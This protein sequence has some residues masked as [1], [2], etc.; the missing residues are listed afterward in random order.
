MQAFALQASPERIT[1]G[2]AMK[3]WE[4]SRRQ[5]RRSWPVL[6]ACGLICVLG[7]AGAGFSPLASAASATVQTLHSFT[8]DGEFP[9]GSLVQA[10]DG[11]FYGTTYGGGA[12]GNGTVFR[13]TPAGALTTVFSFDGAQGRG[14]ISGLSVGSDG[15]L[16]GTT[17]S[18]G[19]ND[20]GTVFRITVSGALTT[21]FH[22]DNTNGAFPRAA[23]LLASDGKIFGAVGQGGSLGRGAI[24]QITAPG[25]GA[26]LFSFDEARGQNPNSA[27]VFGSDGNLYGTTEAGGTNGLGTVFR[28]T[29]TGTLTS[30]FSFDGTAH[31]ANPQAGLLLASDGNFYGTTQ[32]GGANAAGVVFKMTS[33]GIVTTLASLGGANGS[34]SRAAL[35]VGADGNLYGTTFDTLFRITPSG[36]LTTLHTF[37]GATAGNPFAGLVRGADGNFY[38]TTRNG[39]SAGKGSVFRMLAPPG[40]P[41]SLGA[42]AGGGQV[43]LTWSPAAGAVSYNVYQASAAGAQGS[44]PVQTGITGTNATISG[45]ASGN[46]FFVVTSVSGNGESS[47]SNEAAATVNVPN[48]FSFQPVTGASAGTVQLSN[49]VTIGGLLP[50]TSLAISI[51]GDSGAAY[52]IDGAPFRATAGTVANGATVQLQLNAATTAGTTTQAIL[53]VGRITR[54]FDVTTIAS[55]TTPDP[56]AFTAVTGAQPD[57]LSVSNAITLAGMNTAAAI[58]VGGDAGASYSV[59]GS[60]YTA[61][62]GV[63]NA[64]DTVRVRVRAP[65]ASGST[66]A[67][68][69]TVGGVAATYSVTS[70]ADTVPEAFAFDAVTGAAPGTPTVSNVVTIQG[71]AARA[72]VTVQGDP[73]A[74]YSINGGAFTTAAGTVVAGARVQLRVN[75]AADANAVSQA[76]LSVGGISAS[77]SVT[78]GVASS[79]GGGGGGL[80]GSLLLMLPL[81]AFARRRIRS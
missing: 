28:I 32:N 67:V 76:S 16:Y 81:A 1:Q 52:S 43:S 78:S 15:N 6:R 49:I 77:F 42:T 57:S 35:V 59:N 47:P 25:T 60:A 31:G 29:P 68:T 75:A 40:A 73:G 36:S 65:A 18:G 62:S 22:F 12:S 71:I 38:G 74:A 3:D 51:R 53:D 64:G 9:H 2:K 19:S 11:N 17:E 56:F 79:D 63:V 10:S 50:E 14:P 30:L 45:L 69:L 54:S 4:E 7:L 8:S 41:T 46:Y 34:G 13:I 23:P 55:D 24:Y 26:A 20:R 44:T 70:G 39:G 66:S 58:S 33:A 61:S 21:L 80:D 72:A 5:S 48:D 37:S 27:L